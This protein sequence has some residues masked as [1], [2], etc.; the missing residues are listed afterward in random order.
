MLPACRGR[1]IGAALLQGL[2]A[3][4]H[5]LGH[6]HVYCGTSTAQSLLTRAGWQPLE[7]VVLQDKPLTI[8]R[9]LA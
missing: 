6:E 7:T 4:A 2:V 3:K 5:E 9:S 8:F 1:G